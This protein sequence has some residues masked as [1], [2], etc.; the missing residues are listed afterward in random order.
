MK[1]FRVEKMC[2]HMEEER[3][4]ENPLLGIGEERLSGDE[5]YEMILNPAV[6]TG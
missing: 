1:V 5:E 2:V 6:F 4:I 3:W